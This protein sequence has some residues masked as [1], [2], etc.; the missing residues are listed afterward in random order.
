MTIIDKFAAA[1][2]KIIQPSGTFLSSNTASQ[3]YQE[4]IDSI[5]QKPEIIMIDLRN[6]K[7]IAQ[8]GW[9]IVKFCQSKANKLGIKL[10]IFSREEEREFLT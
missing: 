1:N 2:I 5:K 8:G 10:F 7:V 6:F 4:F 9:K 3:I